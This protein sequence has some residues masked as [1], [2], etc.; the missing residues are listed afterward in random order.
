MANILS[1]EKVNRK[2]FEMAS[3]AAENFKLGYVT[4]IEGNIEYFKRYVSHSSVLSYENETCEKLLLKDGCYFV[5]GGDVVDKGNGDIRLCRQLVDLK[6]RY[7]NRVYLLVGNRDLNKLRFSAEL[8]EDD[9]KRPLDSIPGPHWDLKAPTV[10]D[11]LV[12]L[13]KESKADNTS[14]VNTRVN[15][16]KYML[17]HTLGCP[18]TFEFRREELSILENDALE[19]ISDEQVLESFVAEVANEDGSLYQ[20]IQHGNVAVRIGNTLFVHGSVDESNMKYIP[21]HIRFENAKKPQ[22]PQKV[23]ENLDDWVKELN[24]YLKIGLIDYKR[25]PLWDKARE[26]RG[27]ESLMALQNRSAS[28]GRTVVVN[29]YGDG[30]NISSAAAIEYLNDE[31]RR[32]RSKIDPLAFEGVSSDPRNQIVADWL[33]KYGIQRVVVGHK[34]CGDSPAVCSALY[35]GVEFCCADTSYSDTNSVDNRGSAVA[36]TE[37]SGF[38]PFDNSLIL[39]GILRDGTKYESM[40]NRLHSGTRIDDSVG[41]SLLGRE[42]KNRMWVKASYKISGNG[43]DGLMYHCSKGERRNV[44]YRRISKAEI[45]KNSML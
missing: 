36:C 13:A 2:H 6:K 15:R 19:N 29:C 45:M 5:H 34:P 23:I 35:T 22:A 9:M 21:Q 27:G 4:D 37:I 17:K 43:D 1:P 12:Q 33:L 42:L 18:K 30:G 26:S 31:E 39:R 28:W 16:L 11:Y 3:S 7:P 38:S 24:N 10:S 41:D 25:R 40:H 32:Q 44:M 14:I 8:S 20:Y